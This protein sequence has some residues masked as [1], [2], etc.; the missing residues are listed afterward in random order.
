[1]IIRAMIWL[2]NISTGRG[3]RGCEEVILGEGYV[4]DGVV[5]CGLQYKWDRKLFDGKGY[6]TLKNQNGW[7]ETDDFSFVIE[8]KVSRSDFRN[9]FV[10][11][12]NHGG[13]RLI[14]KGNFHF[15]VV[16]KGVIQNTD[17]VPE[18]W[19]VLQESRNGLRLLRTPK[20]IPQPINNLHE[21]AYRILRYT[22]LGKYSIFELAYDQPFKEDEQIKI[23]LT[24]N[25]FLS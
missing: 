18:M 5:I 23:D 10:N 3:I 7:V 1:M 19:G 21:M 9:T 12:G 13:D 16:G 2:S 11:P 17:E 6:F 15:L 20:F 22:K 4:A 25:N 14:P 8:S 24:E